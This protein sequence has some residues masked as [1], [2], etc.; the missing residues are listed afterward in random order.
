MVRNCSIRRRDGELKLPSS[1]ASGCTIVVTGC[2]VIMVDIVGA[3]VTVADAG[4]DLTAMPGIT[5]SVG[6]L[7]SVVKTGKRNI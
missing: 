1:Y 5:I 6:M 2:G 7:P 3:G 4:I